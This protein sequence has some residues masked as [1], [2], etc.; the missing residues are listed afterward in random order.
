MIIS[1][2]WLR[3]QIIN[4]GG[5]DWLALDPDDLVVNVSIVFKMYSLLKYPNNY[6]EMSNCFQDFLWLTSWAR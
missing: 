2:V 6:D 3:E 1:L 4:G 5:P